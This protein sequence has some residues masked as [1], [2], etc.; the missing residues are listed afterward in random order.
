MGQEAV[1]G[2]KDHSVVPPPRPAASPPLWP[3]S[4]HL[5]LQ[6]P[7][8]GAGALSRPRKHRQGRLKPGQAICKLA[9]WGL[10]CHFKLTEASRE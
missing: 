6:G 5:G 3:R 4:A 7:Q 10:A 8:Q 9:A 2:K 1:G